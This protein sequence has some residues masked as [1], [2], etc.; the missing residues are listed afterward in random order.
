MTPQVQE[1]SNSNYSTFPMTPISDFDAIT[2]KHQL[3][4]REIYIV[5][6][7]QSIQY[8]QDLSAAC[9]GIGALEGALALVTGP[10]LMDSPLASAIAIVGIVAAAVS[11]VS[12][13]RLMYSASKEAANTNTIKRAVTQHILPINKKLKDI[14]IVQYTLQDNC[15]SINATDMTKDVMR[16]MKDK[17]TWGIAFKDSIQNVTRVYLFKGPLPRGTKGI[18]VH[19]MMTEFERD[20]ITQQLQ[21]QMA[22]AKPRTDKIQEI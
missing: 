14:L 5:K 20:D 17:K 4:G 9:L 3:T 2:K 12:G 1:K 16:L 21:E 13:V 18:V 7:K 15:L 10:L 8:K 19:R 11:L 6:D 22:G